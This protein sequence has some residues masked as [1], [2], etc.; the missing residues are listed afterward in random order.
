MSD[1]QCNKC[2]QT[3]PLSEFHPHKQCE[4]GYTSYCK[5]CNYKQKKAYYQL[6]RTKVLDGNKEWRD[7]NPEKYK[8]SRL[9]SVRKWRENNK[10]ARKAVAHIGNRI[11]YGSLIRPNNCQKCN[12]A[13]KTEAHHEDYNKPS[14]VFW[15]CRKCHIGVHYE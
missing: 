14:E 13:I 9:D 5:E 15:L 8:A 11:Y 1:K 6:N 7:N 12:E 10:Q 2:L 4:G 3:K